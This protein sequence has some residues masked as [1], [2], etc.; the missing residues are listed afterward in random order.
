ML[1]LAGAGTGKTRVVMHRVVNLIRH[2]VA[3]SRILAVTF[4]NKAAREMQQR[5]AELLGKRQSQAKPEIS[6]FHSLCVRILRRQIHH[7]GYPEQFA[8]YDRGDQES[9]ARAA[10]REIRVSETTMRPGDLIQM[11]SRWKMAGIDPA[12][13]GSVAQ[14]DKEHLAAAGYRRYQNALKAAGAV[15]FDDLLGLTGEVFSR[16]ADVRARGGRPIRP[17]HGRRVPGHQRHPVPDRQGTGRRTP[18]PVRRGRRRPVDLRLARGRG[19][20]HSAIQERLARRQ[21]RPARNQLPQHAADPRVV[22]PPDRVQQGPPREG[23]PVDGQRRGAPDSPG[24]GRDGRGETG[25]RRDRPRGRRP[26]RPA[27]R[28]R[29]S[30]PHERAAPAV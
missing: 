2:G 24:P 19:D 25:R 8:I 1:V 23:A 7:L 20:P 16:H 27:R 15:D 18:E 28:F 3:P 9:V 10:L 26:T 5:A 17:R 29:H 11:V 30:L 14:S 12:R 6:T 13:A 22:Q 4:T 21:N